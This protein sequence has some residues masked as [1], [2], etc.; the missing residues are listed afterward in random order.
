MSSDGYMLGNR[1]QFPF[2]VPMNC[3][4][5]FK[6]Q[7]GLADEQIVDSFRAALSQEQELSQFV[8]VLLD[9]WTFDSFMQFSNAYLLESDDSSA[10]DIASVTGSANESDSDDDG[11]EDG[12]EG[13]T[14]VS[15]VVNSL[16]G[17]TLDT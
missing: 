2:D 17:I 16:D 1:D 14:S 10:E 6:A 5:R 13:Q 7:E 9:S 15:N 11:P 4:Q 12:G 8:N 3:L